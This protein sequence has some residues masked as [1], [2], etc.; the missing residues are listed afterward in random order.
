MNINAT[1]IGQMITF[2]LFVWFTMKFVWPHIL[3][4]M[5]EREDKI[6]D[7]LAAAER[8]R[9]ELAIAQEKVT[10]QLREAKTKAAAIVDTAHKKADQLIEQARTEAVVEKKKIV[11]QA[12][13]EIAQE[14]YQA[15]QALKQ[16]VAVIA[17][18]GAEKIIGREVDEAA[19]KDIL[20]QL[21][22][23]L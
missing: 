16:H 14:K 7:G 17:L 21:I 12:Q 13:E 1:L 9:H 18:S 3:N 20:D 19:N 22:E 6:A 23:E 15:L 4:A 11:Q 10:E 5:Q 2:G 8:G